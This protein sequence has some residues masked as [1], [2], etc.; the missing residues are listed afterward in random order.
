MLMEPI[1]GIAKMKTPDNSNAEN[2][3]TGAHSSVEQ[4]SDSSLMG[5]IFDNSDMPDLE[6]SDIT[7]SSSERTEP[8]K[9]MRMA[10]RF[11]HDDISAS[12][13][14]SGLLSAGKEIPVDLIDIS[15]KGVLISTEQRFAINKKVILTLRFKSNKVF[16]IKA[17][18]IRYFSSLHHQYGIKFN[19]YNNEL[20]DYLLETQEK[21]RFK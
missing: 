18:M 3:M 12:I 8:K 15:S 10:T 19:S 17:M 1:L 5:A 11:I 9:N 13:K 21:L 16:V 20:G 7:A 6:Y 14:T 4:P 2:F